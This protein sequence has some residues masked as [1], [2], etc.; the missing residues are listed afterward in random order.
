MD[1]KM[2]LITCATCHVPFAIAEDMVGRLRKCHNSFYCPNG[3]SNVYCGETKEEELEKQLLA[4]SREISAKE[5]FIHRLQTEI[6]TLRKPA[7]KPR[8]PKSK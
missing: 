3:H 5:T 8:K 2:T 7:R 6:Q 1:I 4:K